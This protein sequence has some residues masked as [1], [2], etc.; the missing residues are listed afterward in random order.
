MIPNTGS[1]VCFGF[2]RLFAQPAEFSACRSLKPMCHLLHRRCRGWRRFGGCS[3]TL[4]PTDMATRRQQKSRVAVDRS[5]IVHG[6]QCAESTEMIIAHS[7][8][9]RQAA[10]TVHTNP[11]GPTPLGG[12]ADGAYLRKYLSEPGSRSS[13]K[14]T[15]RQ[16]SQLDFLSS[17]S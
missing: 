4:F 5:K 14:R 1:G 13:N 10:R 9:V 11:C 6:F 17:E 2:R 12:G 8:Y 15:H 16:T 3:K 7:P